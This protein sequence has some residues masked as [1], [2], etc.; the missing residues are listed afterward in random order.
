VAVACTLRSPQLPFAARAG[1][2]RHGDRYATA[3]PPGP[4]V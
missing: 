1:K 4:G 2:V 3:R